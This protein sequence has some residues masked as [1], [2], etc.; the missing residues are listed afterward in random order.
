M[1]GAITELEDLKSRMKATWMAGDFDKIAQTYE[2]G[3]TRLIGFSPL[4]RTGARR[5]LRCGH[6]SSRR[7]RGRRD[8]PRHRP[9]IDLD[10]ARTRESRR[11]TYHLYEASRT[12]AV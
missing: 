5:G 12:D 1:S 2:P 9:G 7:R 10:G 4:R 8:R 3:H 11:I 6:L